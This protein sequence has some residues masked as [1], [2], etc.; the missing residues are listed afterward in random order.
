MSFKNLQ[1]HKMKPS[2]LVVLIGLF[3][4]CLF[5]NADQINAQTVFEH[6]T[7]TAIYDF[8]DELANS[9][10]IEI[11]SGVKPYSG[12][13]I[14][15]WL[16]KAS[17]HK[18][19]MPTRLRKELEFYLL[20]YNS[21]PTN[22]FYKQNLFLKRDDKISSGF[23]LSR[24]NFFYQDSLLKISIR[25]VLG[26][27]VFS[28]G[29]QN[30]THRW[31]GAEAHALVGE[32][33]GVYAS[34]R[35][36]NES[37]KLTAP[38]FFNQRYGVPVKNSVNK[39]FDYSESRGGI[40][41]FWKWGYIGLVKD[42]FV[43]GEGYHG[44]NI[45]SGRT[46]SFASIILKLEPARWISF[47]YFH[48]WLVSNVVDSSRSYYDNYVFRP[49]YHNKFIAA[50]LLTIS[51]VRNLHL[52]F[53]NSIIYSDLGIHPGYL[54]PF[55]FYKSVDHTLNNTNLFGETGQNSQMFIIISSRQIKKLHLYGNAYFD[56]LNISRIKNGKIHNFFSIKTGFKTSNLLL[57]NF[58]FTGEY[59][60]T[61]PIAYAHKISTTTFTS[62]D[63]NLGHYLKDNSKELYFCL[64]YKPV[65]GLRISAEYIYARHYNDYVYD[66]RPNVDN[67]KPFKNLTWSQKE[68][69]M[70]A[71]Y[72]ILFNVGIM[73]RISRSDVKGYE[74]D[75]KP[76]QYY[77]E[78]YTPE[79]YRGKKTI[80]SGGLFIGF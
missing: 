28:N 3:I 67:D 58:S 23:S 57:N 38:N 77:L 8:L 39:G 14:Q 78:K 75:G 74:A 42:H 68:F 33:L 76:A 53:G 61:K 13:Q 24:L 41:Y 37:G 34:L 26:Y 25:P 56:E 36:N 73:F 30:I 19:E 18:K 10:Y 32:N 50:N 45:L 20:I 62:N 54:N 43:W 7:A 71:R 47:N 2:P 59:T 55:M 60:F 63:F 31:N 66:N 21:E 64:T 70:D 27:Q 80:I 69:A 9:G 4:F 79:I 12:I 5:Y 15:K 22:E 51:P 49:V 52:S 46:P 17:F 11:K 65:R 44:S 40:V 16:N 35:D 48:G 72:D 6:P 1:F 29:N